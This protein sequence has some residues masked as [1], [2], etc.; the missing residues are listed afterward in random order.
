M[1]SARLQSGRHIQ[2][3]SLAIVIPVYNEAEVLP[4][5][6]QRLQQALADTD[7]I[8]TTLVYVDDGSDDTTLE[9]IDDLQQ[10]D[11]RV[12]VVELSR[13]F[14]KEAAIIAG[15]EYADADMVVLIDADLQDPPELIP[16]MLERWQQGYDVA[17][18]TRTRRHGEGWMK[19]LT[20]Y[21]FYRVMHNM[22]EVDIPKDAGDFR[23]L[24]RRAV[25]AIKQLPERSRYSKGLFSWIGY[26]QCSI[27]FERDPR[28]SGTSKWNYRGLLKLASE[29]IMSFSVIPLQFASIAGFVLAFITGIYGIV[30]FTRVLL[31][32]DAV[33]G[34]PS[35]MLAILFLGGIQLMAL[36][37]IGGYLGRAFIESK[38]R[39]LYFTSGIRDARQSGTATTP[40]PGTTQLAAGSASH[41]PQASTPN[42]E[43]AA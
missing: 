24:S 39:P 8:E 17:Y 21:L 22:A 33:A 9:I 10:Q 20:S 40:R 19:R 41:S 31:F 1:P 30:L 27:P 25:E 29:G 2:Q 3:E 12:A 38:Q 32:G 16:A 36:G 42:S 6:Q 18:A 37:I 43:D 4:E 34:Y 5:F 7:T 35:M 15:L 11:S 28:Y 23:L 13:N 14:G 26:P